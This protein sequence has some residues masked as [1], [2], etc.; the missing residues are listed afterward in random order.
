M[1]LAL[2]LWQSSLG[3]SGKCS[4]PVDLQLRHSQLLTFATDPRVVDLVIGSVPVEHPLYRCLLDTQ[5]AYERYAC[6]L[7]WLICGLIHF[8]SP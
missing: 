3:E 7:P 4:S 2:F 8:I 5:A 6:N 1:H